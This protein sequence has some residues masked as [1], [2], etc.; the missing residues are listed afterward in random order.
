MENKVATTYLRR[1]DIEQWGLSE[2]CL[3]CWYLRTGQETTA[4]LQCKACRRKIEALLKGDSSGSVRLVAAGERIN[5][6]L[7]RCS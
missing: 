5:R 1:A 4:S 2:G 7:D 6:A 3:G